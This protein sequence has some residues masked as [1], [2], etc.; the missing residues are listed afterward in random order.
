MVFNTPHQFFCRGFLLVFNQRNAREKGEG[1][2]QTTYCEIR[3]IGELICSG[4][5]GLIELIKANKDRLSYADL[6]G[7][8]LEYIELE[9]A[10][11]QYANLRNA[12]L[13]SA[14]LRNAKLCNADLRAADLEGAMLEGSDLRGANLQYADLY[15]AYLRCADFRGAILSDTTLDGLKI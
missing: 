8:D 4:N 13:T 5:C 10:D 2:S 3:K 6:E 7:A 15:D 1:M 12:R 9:D 11:L 14:N